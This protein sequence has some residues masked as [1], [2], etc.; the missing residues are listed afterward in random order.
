MSTYDVTRSFTPFNV[1][2]DEVKLINYLGAN[3]AVERLRH[4]AL[5][6][7]LG[8]VAPALQVQFG[9]CGNDQ[10]NHEGSRGRSKRSS[11][12]SRQSLRASIVFVPGRRRAANRRTCRPACSCRNRRGPPMVFDKPSTSGICTAGISNDTESRSILVIPETVRT[13]TFLRRTGQFQMWLHPPSFLTMRP[14]FGHCLTYNFM[15]CC[16]SWSDSNLAFHSAS[17]LH[18]AGCQITTAA[19]QISQH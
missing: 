13:S 17:C 6:K 14:Q 5:G 3:F 18:V 11:R 4:L 15:N 2:F 7:F 9:L 16:V 10:V 12:W 1:V 19:L 8:V